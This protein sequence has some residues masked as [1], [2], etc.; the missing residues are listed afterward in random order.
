MNYKRTH[1]D[2]AKKS[3]KQYMNNRETEIITKEQ[4]EILELRNTMSEMKNTIKI[5]NTD[6]IREE[7]I[8]KHE[9]KSLEIIQS[10]EIKGKRMKSIEES[11]CDLW[12]IINKTKIH[13]MGVAEGCR[14]RERNR[15][16]KEIMSENLLN[17][18]RD[19]GIQV[20]KA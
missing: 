15:L 3:G 19:I 2:N 6:L 18:G 20:P 1:I 8:C 13:I 11:P 17:Q 12:D 4:R 7:R 14:N 5:V 16:F 10:V 9:D